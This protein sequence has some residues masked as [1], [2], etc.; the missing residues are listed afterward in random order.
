[1]IGVVKWFDDAKG[2]GF[3]ESEE[4]RDIFVHHTAIQNTGFR[5]LSEGQRVRFDVSQGPKGEQAQN[6]EIL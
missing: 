4:G 6:V 2:Y 3:I 1:M 5:S